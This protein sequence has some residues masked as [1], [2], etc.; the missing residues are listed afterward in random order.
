MTMI[1]N[2][3][4]LAIKEGGRLGKSYHFPISRTNFEKKLCSPI[5]FY[6]GNE[7]GQ[8]LS[9]QLIVTSIYFEIFPHDWRD[10][11]IAYNG[12]D[13]SV[14]NPNFIT[15]HLPISIGVY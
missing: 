12:R 13:M 14:Q 10:I 11:H 8:E 9:I 4:G 2:S 6:F 1:Y 15:D 7:R 5:T 3:A